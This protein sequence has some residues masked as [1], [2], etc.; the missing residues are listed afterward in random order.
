VLV[1]TRA[2]HDVKQ[3]HEE[4]KKDGELAGTGGGVMDDLVAGLERMGYGE[5]GK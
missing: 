3:G 5:S 4:G 2:G 1:P